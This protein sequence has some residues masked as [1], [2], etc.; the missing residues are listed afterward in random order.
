MC[1]TLTFGKQHVHQLALYL[2]CLISAAVHLAV[3]MVHHTWFD[4]V[5]DRVL[6]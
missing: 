6:Q 1:L 2:F 3:Q 5:A 4:S